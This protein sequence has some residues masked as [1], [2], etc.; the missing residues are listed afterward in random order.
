M[1]IEGICAPCS[2]M[3]EALGPG[4]YGALRGHGGWCASVIKPGRIALGDV[5]TVLD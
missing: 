2:R 5:V 3:E 4:G 1:R